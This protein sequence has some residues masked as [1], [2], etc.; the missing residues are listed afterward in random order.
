MSM[1]A[2]YFEAARTAQER[3]VASLQNMAN[4]ASGALPSR[5]AG[6]DTDSLGKQAHEGIDQVFDFW[7]KSMK[8]Q[9]EIAR[10]VADANIEYLSALQGQA[11]A[12]SQ[13]A[14][15]QVKEATA[16]VA[17]VTRHAQDQVAEAAAKAEESMANAANSA[18]R[19]A[20]AAPSRT[21]PSK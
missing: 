10:K 20:K 9:R 14:T 5:M 4:E 12:V 3:W 1:S 11:L 13:Q 16:Q 17:E 18:A 21:T 15:E 7:A 8:V 6:L 19:V 2:Q